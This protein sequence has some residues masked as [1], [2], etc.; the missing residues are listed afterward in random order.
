MPNSDPCQIITPLELVGLGVLEGLGFGNQIAI[1]LTLAVKLIIW[2]GAENGHNTY[3]NSHLVGNYSF[4]WR[5]V[6]IAQR[7]IHKSDTSNIPNCFRFIQLTLA[8]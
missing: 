4:I 3:F 2:Q 6:I 7:I 1:F 5:L 8:L